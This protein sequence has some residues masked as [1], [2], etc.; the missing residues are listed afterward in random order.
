MR[1]GRRNQH[2]ERDWGHERHDPSTVHISSL[3][4]TGGWRKLSPA[5]RVWLAQ[6]CVGDVDLHL[7]A[8]SGDQEVD[9]P[10]VEP[11]VLEVPDGELTMDRAAHENVEAALGWRRDRNRD[12]VDRPAMGAGD[13][14]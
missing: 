3:L 13:R 12:R 4:L 9:Q 2:T 14:W 7:I 8:R 1:P 5:T 6:P 10:G 11:A